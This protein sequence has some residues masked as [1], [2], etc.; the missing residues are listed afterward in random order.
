MLRPAIFAYVR[1]VFRLPCR[2]VFLSLFFGGL[3]AAPPLRA[4]YA[5]VPERDQGRSL[6]VSVRGGLAYDT[7]VFGAPPEGSVRVA[8]GQPRPV[9]PVE[10]AVW[11]L[12]PRVAYHAAATDQTFLSAAYGLTLDYF[13][14]R[15]GDQLLDSHDLS[16]RVA[17]AFTKTTTLDLNDVF[18]VSRNPEA[19]LPGLASLPGGGVLERIANV[20]QSANR[21]QFDGRFNTPLNPKSAATLKARS[22]LYDYR[23]RELGRSLDRVENLYGLA[24]DHALLPEAKVVAEYRHQDMY[25]R[26]QGETKNKHSDYLMAGADYELARKLTLG[27]RLGAEW[28]ERAGERDR[29]APFAE[30]SGQYNYRRASFLVGGYAYTFDE[31]SDPVRFTD[32]Q[33]NRFFAT[34]Q[35]AVTA[36]I[37][38]SASA[39]YEPAVLQG[40]RG[41]RDID[42]TTTRLGVTLSYL[43]AKNWTLAASCDYD[44][45]R[46]DD[47]IRRMRRTRTGLNA[48]Y[49]F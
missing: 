3:I 5:P 28:R 36:L 37:V 32:M 49:S 33:V 17:H 30:L 18:T 14:R 2:T 11:S 35:H 46:S 48:I 10:S 38:A 44:R 21:N 6:I 42:E 31:T 39:A 23:N 4:V 25:Y 1:L 22:V 26:T 20:D 29:T 7:N 8:P 43:R 13:E 24:V 9:V 15:P 19:L 12:A 16:L 40:R 41:Q 34:G 27:G 47:P 45:V